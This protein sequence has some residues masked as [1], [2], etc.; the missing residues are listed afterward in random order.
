MEKAFWFQVGGAIVLVL[1]IVGGFF[2]HPLISAGVVLLGS[3][4]AGWVAGR[5]GTFP[6]FGKGAIALLA[7]LLPL[8]L[9]VFGDPKGFIEVTSGADL[10][11]TGKNANVQIPVAQLVAIVAAFYAGF[12]VLAV[13]LS[14]LSYAP[15]MLMVSALILKALIALASSLK[16]HTLALIWLPLDVTAAMSDLAV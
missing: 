2:I 13:G 10:M 9:C 8:A 12:S 16:S 4:V 7:L 11:L 1:A 3:A 14:R 5:K 15:V 6:D